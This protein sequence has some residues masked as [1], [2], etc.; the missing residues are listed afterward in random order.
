VLSAKR[1]RRN[2]IV[3]ILGRNCTPAVGCDAAVCCPLASH[4]VQAPCALLTLEINAPRALLR[5]EKDGTDRR[6]DGRQTVTLL[7]PPD[8]VRVSNNYSV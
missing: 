7:L 2:V 4:F 5:L 1:W 3:V 6:T 8:V